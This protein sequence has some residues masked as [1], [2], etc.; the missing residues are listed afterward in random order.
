MDV[1][2]R[3]TALDYGHLAMHLAAIFAVVL[4]GVLVIW[5]VISKPNAKLF[6]ADNTVCY[7]QPFAMQCEKR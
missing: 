6:E 2:D 5:L 7:S 3:H 4:L 1:R